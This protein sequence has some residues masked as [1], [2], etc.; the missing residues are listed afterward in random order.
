MNDGRLDRKSVL[1][2]DR[3]WRAV[4]VTT[5]KQALIDMSKDTVTAVMIHGED[6]FEVV[7][8]DRWV[9]IQVGDGEECVHTTRSRIKMPTVIVTVNFTQ[10]KAISRKPKVTPVEVMKAYGG[11]CAY[12]GRNV[13]RNGNIDH[14]KPRSRGGANDWSNVVWSDPEVNAEKGARTP[15]E[16]GL[17]RPRIVRVVSKPAMCTIEPRHDRPEWGLFLPKRSLPR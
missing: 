11:R 10:A 16:A 8:W 9:Q 2:L 5:P 3:T 6:N 12:T 13:G 14:V 1:V 4:N 17:P 7:S 15:E